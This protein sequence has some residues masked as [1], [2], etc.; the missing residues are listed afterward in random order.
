MQVCPLTTAFE[1]ARMRMAILHPCH[2]W[3]PWWTSAITVSDTPRAAKPHDR[4]RGSDRSL[5]RPNPEVAI[6]LCDRAHVIHGLRTPP[7]W[8]SARTSTSG[9]ASDASS[10]PGC[11]PGGC[12]RAP[13][14]ESARCRRRR[15]RSSDA[16][17]HTVSR[18]ISE[19]MIARRD[20]QG[21]VA[22]AFNL[23]HGLH[24]RARQCLGRER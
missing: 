15:C 16:T 8:R 24:A 17:S 10:G 20:S 11:I 3:N 1:S 23:H 21:Q 7:A 9:P 4:A 6:G 14:P 5:T 13:R 12:P 2:P 19:R 18:P 22:E